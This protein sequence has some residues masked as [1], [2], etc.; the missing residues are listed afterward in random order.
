MA[1]NVST[2]TF[3]LTVNSEKDPADATNQQFTVAGSF[4][5]NGFDGQVQF[6]PTTT[7]TDIAPGKYFYDI[8]ETTAGGQK[9]TLIKGVC[10]IIQD[11]TKA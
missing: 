8:Q 9:D 3:A 4:V 10:R 5:T 7:D 1:Q 11:I 2:S 6:E